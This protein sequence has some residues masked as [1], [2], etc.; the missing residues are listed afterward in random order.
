M[1]HLS[2]RVPWND[3]AWDGRVCANPAGN[4]SCLVLPRIHAERDDAVETELAGAAWE[5]LRDH[6][7]PLPPCM[8]EKGDFMSA[9]SRSIVIRHPYSSFADSHQH[10]RAAHIHLPAYS[11][12][13][14]PYRWMLRD[15]AP[16]M[17][18]LIDRRY[19]QAYEEKADQ[20]L[21][22]KT[23]WVQ[24]ARN[25]GELLDGFF[26]QANKG[27]SL[28]FFYAKSTPLFDGPGR[29]LIG[30]GLIEDVGQSVP[31]PEEGNGPIHCLAWERAIRHSIRPGGGAGFLLPYHQLLQVADDENT[32]ID[33]E[34]YV[35][36]APE[37]AW[38]AFSY[39]CEHVPHDAAIGALLSCDRVLERATG[40]VPGD[41]ETPRRWIDGRLSELWRLRGPC[42][43]LGSALTAFDVPQGSLVAYLLAPLLEENADPWPLVDQ[44]F[45][46]PRGV[47]PGLERHLGVMLRRKWASLP[48]DRRALLKLI[49]RFELNAEQATRFYQDTE[50]KK[51]GIEATDQE[52]LRNPYLLFERDRFAVDGVSVETIDRGTFPDPVVRDAHP[53]PS[54]SGVDEAIDPRRVRAVLIDELERAAE[55]GDTLR[56]DS[57][58]IQRIRD[59]PLSPPCPVDR[60]LLQAFREEL[61]SEIDQAE[62]GDG[63]AAMQLRR[64]SATG[65]IIRDAVTRR[66]GGQR[67]TIEADWR[68]L[69]DEELKKLGVP[70][71]DPSSDE[72]QARIEKAGCL[73]EL[74]EARFSVLI[75]AAGTGKTTLLSLIAN[76]DEV[77]GRGVLLLA[78]TGKARVQMQTRIGRRAKTIAQFLLPLDR[79]D[80]RTGEYLITGG[81]REGGFGT[82]IIDECSMLTEEQLAATIDALENV[83]RLILVG[84]PR[85][86]PPIGSGRPF[87]D[88]A[89]HLAP[90]DIEQRFPRVAPGY[91]EL[92]VLRRHAGDERD[93]VQLAEWFTGR[94]VGPG[95]D[96]IWDK[97]ASASDLETLRVESW[98]VDRDLHTTLLDAL[99]EEIDEI[100]SL[101]DVLGFERSIG[102]H[103]DNGWCYFSSKWKDRPGAAARAEDWQI[104]S[105]LRGQ[106]YGVIELNRLIQRQFRSAALERARQ[107]GYQRRVPKP[108]GPE[109]ITY[110]DKVINMRNLSMKGRNV[111][112]PEDALEYVA[113]GEI[114]I[115]VGEFRRSGNRRMPRNIEVEFSSQRGFSYR[116]TRGRFDAEGTSPLELA[117]A[118]TVHK[119]QG[120]EFNR[121]FLVIPTPCRVLSRELLYTALTRQRNRVVL[122]FQGDAGELR[123]YTGPEYSETA[124]RLTNLFVAPVRVEVAQTFLDQNLIHRTS[125]GELVRSKSEVIIANLLAAK[126][127]SYSYERPLDA[128]NGSRRYPDFTIEDAE[129]GVLAYWEHLGMLNSPSYRKSWDRKRQWY[130]DQGI[131]EPSLGDATRG[132]LLCTRDDPSGG[133]DSA[134]IERLVATTFNR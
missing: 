133:I 88:I 92:T 121:T 81:N 57:D 32:D 36:H 16:V 129:T 61:S 25:Q 94:G 100:S 91:C 47:L 46:N 87:V 51:V 111:F 66:I 41:W 18:E 96:E 97:L 22:F 7:T 33:L 1:R 14:V 68:A 34:E 79:Y 76:H 54:P 31:Y 20:L 17:A 74:A 106:G 127:L 118:L 65:R 62:L 124:R 123:R 107:P 122:L 89:T 116:Y 102:G 131:R 93:D 10:F 77:A 4:A 82:V 119:A 21:G 27:E 35:A 109:A 6:D 38:D 63:A 67:L 130:E 42:P 50:R 75:G 11:V 71:A 84:D 48:D 85:Q 83:Q 132:V 49:S 23:S 113:N 99:V 125:R 70:T 60:D 26:G 126:G 56:P 134:E 108:A 45:Q 53:L 52:L 13:C 30:A 101:S 39:G 15:N 8:L 69:L 5:E 64:L 98:H 112:P 40:V 115:V 95:A 72:D 117:Y 80:T 12:G 43:G 55:G 24:D 29:I 114:G 104:F 59:R 78:P 58:V 103:E 73:K 86:L 120:S 128:P 2:I 105:P 44:A 90:D 9:T 19:Q 110:G 3:T 28:C 37:G